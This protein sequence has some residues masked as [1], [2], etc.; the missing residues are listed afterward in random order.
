MLTRNVF[1]NHSIPITQ[2][3]RLLKRPRTIRSLTCR[4]HKHC[5]KCVQD[6][7]SNW[8][9]SP[10]MHSVTVYTAVPGSTKWYS[11]SARLFVPCILLTCIY[12][13]RCIDVNS[14]HRIMTGCISLAL[15]KDHKIYLPFKM[16]SRNTKPFFQEGVVFNNACKWGGATVPRVNGVKF[17]LK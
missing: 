14:I 8:Q 3:R 7:L 11:H 4:S 9:R 16:P 17:R 6:V 2:Y 5:L 1:R 12:C 10:P 15:S 13:L